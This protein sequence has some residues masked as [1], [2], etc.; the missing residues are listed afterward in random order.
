MPKLQ[1]VRGTRDVLPDELRAHRHVFETARATAGLYGY[2][3]MSTPI[4]E[5]TEVFKRTLGDSSDVVTK[6]MYTFE[7]RGGEWITLRPENTAGVARALISGGLSQNLPLKVFCGGPMFRYERP[8]KGRLRQ[9]HQIDVELLG[10]PEA[11][12]DVEIIALGAEVLKALGVNEAVKLELNTLGDSESRAAYRDSLVEYFNAHLADLSEDSRTRL[13]KNPLRILDSKDEGDRHVVAGAPKMSEY[14]NASSHAF[15]AS[16]CAGLDSLGI[17][18]ELNPHLVRGL[19]YYCHSAFEFTTEALG[20]QGAVVA[21]GRYDGLVETMGGPPTPG[22]GW[23]AGVERLAMLVG[24]VAAE[25]YTIAVV[26]VGADME[27]AG[28]VLTQQLRDAGF[29]T[30]MAFRGNL[31]KRL[32]RANKL[33]AVCA[34]LLGEEEAGRDCVTVRDLGSGEQQEVGNAELLAHLKR[35]GA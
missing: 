9:F 30:D 31:S 18:Y 28:F 16:V 15:F 23:A 7:D 8:Q 34:V 24:D 4:F 25:G 6:E 19:D 2:E 33:G 11:M 21:G 35:Y 17:E 32:K 3:E 22:V 27:A 5:F 10:V 13:E 14:L 1:P 26:P 29:R 12:G 20:A